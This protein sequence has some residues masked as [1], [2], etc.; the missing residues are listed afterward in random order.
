MEQE[1]QKKKKISKFN[2]P[3]TRLSKH[4]VLHLK[5]D[6]SKIEFQNKGI[7]LNSFRH[8]EFCLK[9]CEKWVKPHFG[10]VFEKDKLS[11]CLSVEALP[12]KKLRFVLDE[13]EPFKI[14]GR[15]GM[16]K[17]FHKHY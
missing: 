1:F 2:F 11:L 12:M 3:T 7:S 8:G 6:F 5:F 16:P 10:R 13:M 17:V 4:R 15:D 9:V 14:C